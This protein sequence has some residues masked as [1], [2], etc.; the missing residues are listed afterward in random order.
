MKPHHITGP[1][2]SSMYTGIIPR[3]HFEEPYALSHFLYGQYT[4]ENYTT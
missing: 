4:I 2:Q 1:Y 3:D